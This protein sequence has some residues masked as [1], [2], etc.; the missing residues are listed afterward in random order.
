MA[1]NGLDVSSYD[2]QNSLIQNCKTAGEGFLYFKNWEGK[3][4]GHH[5]RQYLVQSDRFE[6]M[7]DYDTQSLVYLRL[8]NNIQ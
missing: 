3:D 4:F 8:C 5:E 7:K 2:I 6:K 1:L